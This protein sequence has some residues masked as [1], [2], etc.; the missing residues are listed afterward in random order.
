LVPLLL[1]RP[2][3]EE[4]EDS[5]PPA[6]KLKYGASTI[7]ARL[8]GP[9]KDGK[10][11]QKELPRSCAI[12][13]IVNWMVAYPDVE[14]IQSMCISTLPTL[15]EDEDQRSAAQQAGLPDVILRSMLRFP[16]NANLHT[17]A[18]HAIVLLAR[19]I[20]GR[21]GMLFDNSMAE[22]TQMGLLGGNSSVSSVESST[23]RP[24]QA[25]QTRLGRIS[26]GTAILLDSMKRFQDNAKLQSMACWSMVNIA[27][28]PTQKQALVDLGG[29][30]ATANAMKRHP[31]NADV[32][33]RALFGLINLVVPCKY[34]T[35]DTTDVDRTNVSEERNTEV[36]DH[37]VSEIVHL[38]VAAMQNFCSSETILNRACLVLHNLSQ[39]PQYLGTLLWTPHCY[40]MLE[41]CIQNHP[42]DQVLKRSAV[43][44]LH[45]LQVMLSSD[46]HLRARFSDFVQGQKELDLPQNKEVCTNN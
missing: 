22:P 26:S 2:A 3:S 9:A 36:L 15:L 4:G 10:P 37:F 33:F 27:L 5:K 30:E 40:Q 25:R 39:T 34:Q 32:Q 8:L 11:G 46:D 16:D 17:S 13:S 24:A 35:N 18:F 31:H 20:G 14:G 42:I 12:F 44:T 45:R 43:S 29:F 41:W 1:Q 38:V 28:S 7:T 21:E 23:S 19:P 6:K